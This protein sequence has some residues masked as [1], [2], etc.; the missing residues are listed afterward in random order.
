MN[1]YL[2]LCMYIHIYDL[3]SWDI[4]TVCPQANII[5]EEEYETGIKQLT[6]HNIMQIFLFPF[7]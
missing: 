5:G 2:C 3:P 6:L 1:I 7:N 4:F